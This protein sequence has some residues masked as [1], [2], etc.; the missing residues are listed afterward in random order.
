MEA[1][2]AALN[3]YVTEDGS[4]IFAYATK[5]AVSGTLATLTLKDEV[6]KPTEPTEPTEPTDEDCPSKAFTD[7]STTAWYHKYVD[8]VLRNDIMVGNGTGNGKLDP[9][10]TATRAQIAVIVNKYSQ[11]LE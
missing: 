3:S 1:T 5:E 7:L 9:K 2:D 4:L 11:N 10:A 8:Y 6:E